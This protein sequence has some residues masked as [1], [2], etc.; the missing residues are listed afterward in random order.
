MS[1][2]IDLRISFGAFDEMQ[3]DEE[4][5]V[6]VVNMLTLF[7]LA[8]LESNRFLFSKALMQDMVIILIIERSNCSTECAKCIINGQDR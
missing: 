6:C 2:L 1:Y 5:Q 4:H 3:L 7:I 8:D